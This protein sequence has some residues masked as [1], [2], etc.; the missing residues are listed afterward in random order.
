MFTAETGGWPTLAA[1]TS[2]AVGEVGGD[3]IEKYDPDEAD[4]LDSWTGA[5]VEWNA[6]I[7]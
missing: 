4:E 1:G 2:G 7:I 3:R 5:P 6:S